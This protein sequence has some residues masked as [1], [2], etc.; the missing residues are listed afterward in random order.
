MPAV[1]TV[2]GNHVVMKKPFCVTRHIII[3]DKIVTYESMPEQQYALLG[4][5]RMDGVDGKKLRSES[6]KSALLFFL[7]ASIR[8]PVFRS[9]FWLA[10]G[11]AARVPT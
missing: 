7:V 1:V 10:A 5:G 9:P 11:T 2:G 8:W 3:Q 4:T 6:E